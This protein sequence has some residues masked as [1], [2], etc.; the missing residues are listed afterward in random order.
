MIFSF[1]M[2]G[3]NSF[4]QI[5]FNKAYDFGQ[6][7][8]GFGSLELSGDTIFV[9]GTAL[10]EGQP[11]FGMLFARLDTSGN[12]IDYQIYNDSLNDDFTVVYP[13]SF[14]RQSNGSGYAGVGQ[15]FN[16]G[17]GYFTKFDNSGLLTFLKEFPDPASEVD[18][19]KEIQELADGFLILGDKYDAIANKL[20]VFV[21]KTDFDG[22]IIWEKKFTTLGRQTLFGQALILNENEYV[23]GTTTTTVQGVPLPQVTNT[24]KIFAID[25]L[26]NIKWEWQSQPSLEEAGVGR[27]FKTPEGNWAYMSGRG[28]YNATYNE[29]SQQPKFII[30]DENFNLIK[31]DTFGVADNPVNGLYNTIQMNDGGWLAVGVKP[32]NYPIPPVP[33]WYNSFSGWMVRLDNQGEQVWSRIDTS[34]WSVET[35][36]TNY[37][38]DAVELPS[39]SIIACG[40]S[41]TYEPEGKDWGWLIKVNKDGCV[42]TLNCTP[43]N[44]TIIHQLQ[45]EINIYPNPTQS[46]ININSTEIELWDR[47]EVISS[48]GKIVKILYKTREN[49]I[50]LSGLEDGVY[51]VRLVKSNQSVTKKIIKRR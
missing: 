7:A 45:N 28:W 17:N 42:D 48:A 4:S 12:L 21:L 16:R 41:R 13:N 33:M 44:T 46:L 37:L 49:K 10:E 36:S 23:I 50:D 2:F 6:L 34:F 8:A 24:S 31:E 20:V 18:F 25:S 5:G 43:L 3:F 14:I 32:V 39:G 1:S 11:A 47:I 26:G 19:Y 40:Y 29:I 38:Y 30:R 27:I 9:Y 22:N 51:F 35:G 15:F